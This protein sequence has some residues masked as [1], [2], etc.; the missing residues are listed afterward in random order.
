MGKRKEEKK[1]T[2]I[3]GKKVEGNEGIDNDR[4]LIS[5]YVVVTKMECMK[6]CKRIDRCQAFN[7]FV[8]LQFIYIF[9]IYTLAKTKFNFLFYDYTIENEN[10][11][12]ACLTMGEYIRGYY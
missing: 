8:F 11:L 1:K 12:F 3:K 4:T 5:I 7:V 10:L 6:Y 2:T 9:D